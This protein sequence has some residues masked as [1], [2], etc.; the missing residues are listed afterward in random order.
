[1]AAICYICKT[2]DPVGACKR[3]GVLVRRLHGARNSSIPAWKCDACTTGGMVGTA[4][5]TSVNRED[6]LDT[7]VGASISRHWVDVYYGYRS[8]EGFVTAHGS[9]YEEAIAFGE[10]ERER[11]AA[12]LSAHIDTEE[13]WR[14]LG[15]GGCTL[16]LWAVAIV[17]TREIP[18]IDLPPGL[19]DVCFVCDVGQ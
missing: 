1:M 16:V 18:Q 14:L 9:V 19:R 8:P 6:L 11:I 2:G 5:A 13:F 12:A 15:A 17:V 10:R 3:C 4:V 7:P